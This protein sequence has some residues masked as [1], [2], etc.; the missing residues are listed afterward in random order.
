MFCR[1]DYNKDNSKICVGLDGRLSSPTLCKALE[2]GLTD[3]GAEII[4][5][6]VVPTPVLYFFADKQFMSAG[7]MVTGSHN[8]R[9]D[10]G[11]KMLQHGKS[12]SVIRYR[13][14]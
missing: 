1:N 13:I 6:G 4:N 11:F 3:A 9:D 10:N 14:Y 7:I 8:P 12:F 2:L 5:I